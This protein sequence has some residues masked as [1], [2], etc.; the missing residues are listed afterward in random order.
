MAAVILT[1]ALLLMIQSPAITV[2]E[3]EFDTEVVLWGKETAYNTNN[4][5]PEPENDWD[6][7]PPILACGTV[8]S[9]RVVA[10]GVNSSCREGNWRENEWPNF[11]DAIL[12]WLAPNKD[13]SS[14][15]VLWYEG[16]NVYNTVQTPNSYGKTPC[17]ALADELEAKGYTIVAT[18]N[19]PIADLSLNDFDIFI[20]PQMQLGSGIGGGDPSLL[21]DADVTAIKNFVEGGGG[22]LIMEQ[23]DYKG[24]NW[25][26]VQNKVLE[27]LGLGVRFQHDAVYDYTSNWGT[28]YSPV[29]DIDTTTEIGSIYYNLTGS[30]EIGLKGPSSLTGTEYKKPPY[31][32]KMQ[33]SPGG[34]VGVP[35]DSVSF[36]LTIVN[37]GENPDNYTLTGSDEKGWSISFSESSFGLAKDESKNVEVTVTVPTTVTEKIMDTVTVTVQGESGVDASSTFRVVSSIP[38]ENP[39]YDVVRENEYFYWFSTATLRVNSPAVPILC[40]TETGYSNDQTEREP[41]PMLYGKGEFPPVAAAALLGQGRVIIDGGGATLRSSPTDHYGNPILAG[42]KLGPLMVRWL[43]NW[44]DPREHRF[45]YYWASGAFH[46]ASKM[47]GWLNT[48]ENE[49]GFQ[50]G[51][52]NGVTIT[53]ELLENYDVLHIVGTPRQF[54]SS[55]IQAIKS[56]VEAGGGLLLAEQSDYRGYSYPTYF[57][58][59]LEG[60]GIPV[61]LQD[62]QLLDN[63]QNAKDPWYPRVYLLD[64]REVNSEYDVW[65]PNHALETSIVAT[66]QS[67]YD[68]IVTFSII[69][70]NAGTEDAVYS[71]SV[72]PK[73]VRPENIEIEKLEALGWSYSVYPS[74]NVSVRA[75]DYEN[76]TIAVTIPSTEEEML[77]EWEVTVTDTEQDFL[78]TSTTLTTYAEA[79]KAK[80][81]ETP[82]VPLELIA[83]AVV[84]I[85]AGV[86]AGLAMRGGKKPRAKR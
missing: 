24:Y 20:I 19:E 22:L 45:L 11:M 5:D 37:A 15:K 77:V 43:I 31:L 57:N 28:Y 79:P 26:K 86:G 49:L 6:A 34:K 60:L 80:P 51:L 25:S 83:A 32:V 54:S 29:V 1:I 64:P 52:E 85:A 44:E 46:D 23:S 78:T 48:I 71:I 2:A 30:T 41:W 40:G 42:S 82:G 66:S 63:D 16:Y 76:V 69:I 17:K 61:E 7:F 53:S 21:P 56:W 58:E 81:E 18:D 12:R 36:T 59:I 27:G 67:G 4:E 10:G 72:T 73:D 3:E 70:T 50:L 68:E 9:G 13:P 8:G 74:E 65:F 38:Q 84:I 14:I 47:S 39:P 62:D 55:E 33:V 35:G 75:G